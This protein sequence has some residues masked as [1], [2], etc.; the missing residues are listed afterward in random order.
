MVTLV[1]VGPLTPE[2]W[3]VSLDDE[4]TPISEHRTRGDAETSARAYAQTFGFPEIR[5]VGE[6]GSENRIIMNAPDP[7]PPHPGAAKGDPA[8]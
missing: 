6:D 7:R 2:R 5:V 4:T 1:Y 3:V 8:G